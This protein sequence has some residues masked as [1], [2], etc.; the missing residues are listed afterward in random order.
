[1]SPVFQ[2]TIARRDSVEAGCETMFACGLSA[3]IRRGDECASPRSAAEAGGE[4][5]R[6]EEPCTGGIR[7]TRYRTNGHRSGASRSP[8][9]R[10]RRIEA[11]ARSYFSDPEIVDAPPRP[12]PARSVLGIA[13]GLVK[14]MSRSV[15]EIFQ[16][17]TAPTPHA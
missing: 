6:C 14:T 2:S 16:L 13:L 3:F 11:I 7:R 15:R 17:H 1:M 8:V 4:M 10:S 9:V 12:A 5:W